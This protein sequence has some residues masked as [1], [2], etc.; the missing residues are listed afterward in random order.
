MLSVGLSDDKRAVERVKLLSNL[1]IDVAALAAQLNGGE[2]VRIELATETI[3][4]PLTARLWSDAIFGRPIAAGQLFAEIMGDRRAALLALGLAA[5]DDDTLRYFSAHPNVLSDLYQHGAATFAAFGDALR[6]RGTRVVPYGGPDA[7]LVW[8][9]VLGAPV[10]QP[11][12]FVRALFTAGRGRVALLYQTLAHLDVPRVRFALGSWMPDPAARIDQFKEIIAAETAREEWDPELRPF[13]RPVHDPSLLLARM[14]VLPTGAPAPPAARVFWQRALESTDL[15]D[16]PAR[17]LR[18]AQDEG[19]ISA[20][21]LA[22][23]VTTGNSSRAGRS[24]RSARVRPAGVRGHAGRGVARRAE[25]RAIDAPLPH[26]HARARPD[27]C[28]QRQVVRG[29]G[30]TCRAHCRAQRSGRVYRAGAVPVRDCDRRPSRSRAQ[31]HSRG[32]GLARGCPRSRPPQWATPMPAAS[33]GGSSA[34]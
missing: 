30:E 34:R 18:N 17:L 3:P 23:N 26:A 29:G 8:E 20:G 5:L 24:R 16:D 33:R 19:P 7:V 4:V 15:S 21:W 27:G 31:S 14:R 22:Q 2:T 25:R 32:G 28:P 11:E 6:I 13:V 10:A 9:A 12:L 1:G